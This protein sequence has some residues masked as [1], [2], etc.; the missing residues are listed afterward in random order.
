MLKE[1][2]FVQGAVAKKDLLP[3]MTHFAIENSQVRSYNGVIALSSPLPFAID[4]KPKADMLVKA[5]SNCSEVIELS[6]TG[7]G[8]LKIQSGSFKAFIDCVEGETPHVLPEG[9]KIEVTGEQLLKAFKTLYPFIADDA[10]RPWSNGVLLSGQSAFATNNVC[11]VE[12]WL[13]VQ[14]PFKVN[15]PY[16]AVRELIRI[17]E[18]PTHIQLT[19]NSITFHYENNR[20]IRSQLYSTE[21]PDLEKILSK[22]VS[23]SPINKSI[24][25]GIEAVASFCDKSG[26]IFFCGNSLKTHTDE[27]LG[28][29]FDCEN[30]PSDGIYNIEMLK[31]LKPVVTTID[32][33]YPDASLFYGENLRGAIIGMRL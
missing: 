17:N 9:Q 31:L 22:Q 8:R 19:D 1:L 20:W 25:E 33:R 30:L 16:Q 14:L 13:G 21:W 12:Y 7:A 18:A 4:C 29:T 28:A 23:P 15:I 24:F 5:I 27:G 3:A 2:K 10:S 26:R 11:L 32:W 6:M